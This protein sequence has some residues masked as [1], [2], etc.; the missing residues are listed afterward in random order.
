M[1]IESAN[2]LKSLSRGGLT[3][4]P[5]VMRIVRRLDRPAASFTYASDR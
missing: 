1:D 3:G 5:V 2:P 4:F